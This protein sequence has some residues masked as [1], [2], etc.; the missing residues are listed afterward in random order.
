M[1]AAHPPAKYLCLLLAMQRKGKRGGK[2]A[3]AK[4]KG[5][6]CKG[7]TGTRAQAASSICSSSRQQGTLA[8]ALRAQGQQQ[9]AASSICSCIRQQGTLA[10][11]LGHKGNSASNL[12][13]VR[14]CQQSPFAFCW[15]CKQRHKGTLALAL[16]AQPCLLCPPLFPPLLLRTG[17]QLLADANSRQR[18]FA[19]G[20]AAGISC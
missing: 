17:H 12:C 7:A 2:S 1:P 16:R 15:V 11:A 3:T 6:P 10:W 20:C 4:A 13:P 18:Y 5:D 8:R 19:G 9:Q 14:S